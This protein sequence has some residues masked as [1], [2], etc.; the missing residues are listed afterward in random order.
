MGGGEKVREGEE[1]RKM[2]FRLGD[3][4]GKSQAASEKV[5]QT[6]GIARAKALG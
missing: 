5:G 6:E 2:S 3:R 1:E 4:G